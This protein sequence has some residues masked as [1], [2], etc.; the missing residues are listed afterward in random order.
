MMNARAEIKKVWDDVQAS[1]REF[2]SHG[3]EAST[4]ALEKTGLKLKELEETL[5]R[6]AE[7]LK[8]TGNGHAAEKPVETP[9]A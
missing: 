3:L 4:R 1:A 2:A 5:K 6:T 9:K 7:K 8:K